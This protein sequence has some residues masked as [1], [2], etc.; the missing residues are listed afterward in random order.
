M[1]IA[2]VVPCYNG[3]QYIGPCL[4]AIGKQSYAPDEVLVIDDGST[5]ESAALA[6]RYPVRLIRHPENLGLATARNTAL[7]QTQADVIVYVDVDAYADPAM[8]AA[9]VTP[10]QAEAVTGVGG[11]GIEVVRE[12]LYDRWRGLHA[13][14]SHGSQ[15]RERCAHLYGLCMAYRREAL[16]KAGG[17]DLRFRT[18]AEDVDMGFRLNDLGGCLRYVPQAR[19]YH[20][21]RDDH[22]SLRRTVY[23]WY[24][25][26]FM[27]KR[28]NGR[29][30]ASTLLAGAV[31]RLVWSDLWPDLL[32]R[33][34][35]GL[36][37][38]DLEM[39]VVR[40]QAIRDAAQAL[41]I[42]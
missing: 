21:R 34:S 30:A 2:I 14:Q 12:T 16:V 15:P 27:A 42:G 13:S 9:L 19:V 22:Q 5:D 6:A 39:F 4:Q 8:L 1:K 29:R 10:F 38:L 3:A 36:A 24:Y 11:Q 33:R 35:V 18:N 7:A 28:K 31:R 26:G 40:L 32:V 25:W 41:P 20:Q 37:K 23:R 17:F